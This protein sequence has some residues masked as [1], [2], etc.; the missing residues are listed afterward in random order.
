MRVLNVAT[1]AFSLALA[2]SAQDYPAFSHSSSSSRSSTS[3][4]S[5]S[6]RAPAGV[7]TVPDDRISVH[8]L[9][10]KPSPRASRNLIKGVTLA[11]KGQHEK[12]VA[13]LEKS[14]TEAPDFFTAHNWLGVEYKILHRV[15]EAVAQF[16]RLI[17]LDP[18]C[19]IGY[20]NLAVIAFNESR[21]SDAEQFARRALQVDSQFNLA[22]FVLA[23]SLLQQNREAENARRLLI[24]ASRTIPAATIALQSVH[25]LRPMEESLLPH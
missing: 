9:A 10:E 11:T 18:T 4:S 7:M 1:L 23:M 16:E 22:Q 14:V 2:A 3:Q 12:A 19:P 13:W 20:T 24:A 17:E 6:G 21:L 25:A 8:Q 15:P 5:T